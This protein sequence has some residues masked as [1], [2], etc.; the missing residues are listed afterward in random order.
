MASRTRVERMRCRDESPTRP[1]R[2]LG[3]E[4]ASTASWTGKKV[5]VSGYRLKSGGAT[6]VKTKP[7]PAVSGM[8]LW[9]ASLMDSTVPYQK[10]RQ[11]DVGTALRPTAASV[12]LNLSDE[13]SHAH[14]WNA[15]RHQQS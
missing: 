1:R 11:N 5:R 15:C 12:V 3:T 2:L 13:K 10:T 6:K 8:P 14:S 4:H 7:P 9:S